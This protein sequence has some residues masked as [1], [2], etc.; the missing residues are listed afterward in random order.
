MLHLSDAD[1]AEIL[2][3]MP[4]IIDRLNQE[5]GKIYP[6]QKLLSLDKDGNISLAF[7][8]NK[9]PVPWDPSLST[10]IGEISQLDMLMRD[11]HTYDLTLQALATGKEPIVAV[12]NS[13]V[14][15]LRSAFEAQFGPAG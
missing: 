9:Q 6:G 3:E 10:K 7:D 12:G 5:F 14:S 8:L 2:T 15:T 13:H 11:R 1:K 4:S